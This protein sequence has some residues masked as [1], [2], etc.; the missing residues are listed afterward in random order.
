MKTKN[1]T[2]TY[3]AFDYPYARLCWGFGYVIVKNLYVIDSFYKGKDG[4]NIKTQDGI[5][6][7]IYGS[8]REYKD[9]GRSFKYSNIERI[10]KISKKEVIDKY[11]IGLL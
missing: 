5:G 6:V 2:R 9:H 4:K 11:F 10:E 8:R 3:K 7:L 1:R